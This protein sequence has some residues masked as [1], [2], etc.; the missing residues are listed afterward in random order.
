MIIK[1]SNFGPIKHY[2]FDLKKDIQLV[3]GG[4]SVGKSYAITVVYLILKSFLNSPYLHPTVMLRYFP[5]LAPYKLNYSEIVTDKEKIITDVFQFL[6]AFIEHTIIASLTNSF[7]ATFDSLEN[8][9]NQFTNK[10][11]LIELSVDTIKISIGINNNQL[12]VNGIELN[13][14]IILRSVKT[15]RHCRVD[16]DKIILYY[17]ENDIDLFTKH[18]EELASCLYFTLRAGVCDAVESVH[19]LPASRSGLYQALSAFGQ[20]VAE[21][22][23]KRSFLNKKI[24]L[25]GIS[26]PLSDYFISLSDIS[27]T[28]KP[29]V[30]TQL[31]AIATAI[32]DEVLHGRVEFDSK[33]KKIMFLPNNTSL[34]LDLSSTSS[35][36]SELSPIVSFVR[37]I[38]S[39]S[40]RRSRYPGVPAGENAK[41]LMVIEEPEAHLHPENQV[42]IMDIFSRLIDGNVKLIITSHSNYIFNKA[43]NLILEGRIPV[44]R[45]QASIFRNEE[46]GSCG[47]DIETDNLGMSDVNFIDV[48]EDLYEEKMVLIERINSD[49]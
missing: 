14:Q 19:F 17:I 12:E 6:K 32:E 1:I 22:S 7:L 9:Q 48:A 34:K 25:P 42:K 36:V 45:L 43:N 49:N 28:R 30:V 4:N 27:V 2:V 3:F 35:M 15:N 13:K 24:E 39:R 11:L 5:Q 37:Y 46:D 23:K 41:P 21:L 38:L 31:N 26:E 10:K 29:Q 47:E 16:R 18:V 20:I 44:D 33:A 40:S 8:L